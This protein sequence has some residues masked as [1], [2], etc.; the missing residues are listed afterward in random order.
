MA[1]LSET[2]KEALWL[3]QQT[4]PEMR[5]HSVFLIWDLKSEHL[6]TRYEFY[7]L[8]DAMPVYFRSEL[9]TS[10]ILIIFTQ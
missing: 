5:L 3:D 9:F 6:L 7:S 4:A 2:E 1:S 10:Y 8:K